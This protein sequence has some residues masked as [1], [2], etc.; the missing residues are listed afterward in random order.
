MK[1]KVVALLLAASMCLSL[2]ACGGQKAASS[3]KSSKSAAVSTVQPGKLVMS[4]NAAFAP[5]ESVADD[6][7]GYKG[8]GYEGIDVEI[9]YAVAQQLGLELEI[10]DMDFSAA[11]NAPAQGKADLCMAGLTVTPER[12]KNLDFSTAYANGVQVVI[13]PKNSGIEK[14]ADLSKNKMIGTQEGTTGYLYCSA[15]AKDGGYGEKHVIAYDSGATAVQALLAKKVDAVVIDKVPAQEYVMK[16]PTLTI[17]PA[18]FT[19][20]HYAIAV[21]KGNAALLKQ[22]NAA[23]K[24]LTANGTV[25]S[26]VDKYISAM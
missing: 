8:T 16:N 17:L 20:E 13:A 25:K 2:T 15:S 14:I 12:K 24:E 1:K 26:I 23:L 5:Y 11:V 9:A 6:G 7:K 18:A 22:I 4:T 3:A 19:D 21:K 10:D